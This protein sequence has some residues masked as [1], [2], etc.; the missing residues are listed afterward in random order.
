VVPVA[1]E[2]CSSWSPLF[3]PVFVLIVVAV[4]RHGRS[5]PVQGAGWHDTD[6]HC[7][8]LLPVIVHGR[9]HQS[10]MLAVIKVSHQ[11]HRLLLQAFVVAGNIL[12]T[13]RRLLKNKRSKSMVT[14]S[15]VTQ[16]MVTQSLALSQ[17][18]VTGR[19]H[20]AW[21]LVN[22]ACHSCGSPLLSLIT[23]HQ[24]YCSSWLRCPFAV[25][26]RCRQV[27]GH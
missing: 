11:C 22:D 19:C 17:V 1:G 23:G 10:P 24:H 27:S 7:R 3:S 6:A 13:I 9:C 2:C 5:S 18:F 20:S 26:R 14:Q 12:I 21:S 15:M 8:S 16:S 4:I 25:S